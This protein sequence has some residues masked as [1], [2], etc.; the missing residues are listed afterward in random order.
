MVGHY[1]NQRWFTCELQWN[2]NQ[3]RTIFMQENEF[4]YVICKVWAILFQPDVLTLWGWVTHICISKITII[5]S[6]NDLS[7]GRHY[8]NQCWN[9]VNWTPRTNFKEILVRIHTF[10]FE[11]IH[12]KMSSGKWWPFCLGLN[13]LTLWPSWSACLEYYRKISNIRR[14][15]SQNLNA[16]RLDL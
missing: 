1:L 8:L 13:V 16:S 9:I 10:L 12:L 6:D 14:T 15:K 5:G 3:Y 2:V 11:K 7:P 4:E